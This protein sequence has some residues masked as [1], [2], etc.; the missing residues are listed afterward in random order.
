ML[1]PRA[2][3]V[4][5]CVARISREAGARVKKNQFLRDLNIIVPTNDQRRDRGHRP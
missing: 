4:E 3:S 2:S 1:M 5:V